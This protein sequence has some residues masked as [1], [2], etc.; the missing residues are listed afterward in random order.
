MSA[1]AS[2]SRAPRHVP[3]DLRTYVPVLPARRAAFTALAKA[4]SSG[5]PRIEPLWVIPPRIRRPADPLS[6]GGRTPDEPV[7]LAHHLHSTADTLRS[8]HGLLPGWV[9][10]RWAEDT[11]EL[12]RE[13]VWDV[14]ASDLAGT[15]L[16]PVT[17]PERGPVQQA[18]AGAVAREWDS[19]LGVR[20]PADSSAALAGEVRDRCAELLNRTGVPPE[21]TDLLIDLRQVSDADTAEARA[22]RALALLADL[23]PWRTTVL[24]GGSFPYSDEGLKRHEVVMVARAEWLVWT[25]LRSRGTGDGLRGGG[26]VYGDY[27]TLHPRSCDDPVETG[28]LDI[29]EKPRYTLAEHFLIGKGAHRTRGEASCMDRIARKITKY[30][31]FR[32]GA[33]AAECWLEERAADPSNKHPGNA[34]TWVTQGHIQ[35]LTYIPEQLRQ[36]GEL[37]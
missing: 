27:S 9:D 14:L 11:L 2:A 33:S 24:T 7:A 13:H 10:A 30:A 23:A 36:L 34:E 3:G 31:P 32:P 16:R 26:L 25:A 1:A 37:G 6:S 19:A 20:I 15:A 21:R 12:V 18:A 17:G 8:R 5:E 28:P 29:F 35:H 22:R 4:G